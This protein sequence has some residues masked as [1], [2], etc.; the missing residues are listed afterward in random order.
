MTLPPS[1]QRE[2]Q[3]AVEEA[4]NA[5]RQQRRPPHRAVSTNAQAVA[6]SPNATETV[7]LPARRTLLI[8]WEDGGV[9]GDVPCA[10][11]SLGPRG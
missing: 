11:F 4:A 6:V 2:V 5:D 7:F 1:W 3:K 10:V 9:Y 8:G